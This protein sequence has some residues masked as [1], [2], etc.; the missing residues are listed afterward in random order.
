M[1]DFECYKLYVSLKN[2]FKGSYDYF[3]Y[4]GKNKVNYKSFEKRK[5]KIFFAKLAKHENV[6]NFLVANFIEH[7]NIWVRD[8]AYSEEAEKTYQ[9]WSKRQQSL[10]YIF[11]QDISKLDGSFNNNLIV[12]DNQ[13]PI[14][15]KEYLANNITFETLCIILEIS[16]GFKHWNTELYYDPIWEQVKLKVNKY[17][18]FIK[19]DKEKFKE[20]CLDHFID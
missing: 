8:L 11:K 18:P 20:I 9:S 5:D 16:N 1:T 10:T 13:H 4:Q 14:L 2:H 12:V 17:T 3:K 6:A 7:S 19:Y 15:L